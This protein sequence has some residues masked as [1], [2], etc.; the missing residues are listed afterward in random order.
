MTFHFCTCFD[1]NYLIYGY[2][3]YRSLKTTGIEFKLYVA[4]LDDTVFQ[5][6]Q[7]L[8]HPEIIPIPLSDIEV[9]DPEFSAC[10]ENRSRVEYIFTLSPVLPLYIL[11]KFPEI[12]I[13]GYLDSDLYFFSS[14]EPVYRRLGQA[15]LLIFEHDF[16]PASVDFAR[17]VGFFNMSFQLYRNDETGKRCLEKWRRQCIEWCYDF[18]ENGKYADQKYLDAWPEEFGAISL[19]AASGAGVAPWNCFKY[20]F[21]FTNKPKIN[22]TDLISYHYQGTKMLKYGM[23]T[24]CEGIWLPYI[25]S[26]FLDFFVRRYYIELCKSR[27]ILKQN[28][29]K[30]AIKTKFT[31]ARVISS[32]NKKGFI[33]RR[34]SAYI[35]NILYIL[36]GRLLFHGYTYFALFR[37]FKDHQ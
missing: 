22:G 24:P 13:L 4:C 26:E 31:F 8:R 6:L 37:S 1:S 27:D 9:G 10:K 33:K 36:T 21:I 35:E 28:L 5:N 29:E 23:I 25:P 3:L 19:N 12:D 14:P 32:D 18:Y 20:Q 7:T 34:L 16:A 11:R 30:T 15:S 17:K 2:T